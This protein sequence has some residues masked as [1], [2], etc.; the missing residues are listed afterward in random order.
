[1]NEEYCKSSKFRNRF[2]CMVT[3]AMNRIIGK[4]AIKRTKPLKF[5]FHK[6][7]AT[8]GGSIRHISYLLNKA[9]SLLKAFSVNHHK[10]MVLFRGGPLC[11]STWE[12]QSSPVYFEQS[13]TTS[14]QVSDSNLFYGAQG[15]WY[16]ISTV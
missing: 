13:A 16:Q 4:S 1:M 8:R 14:V 2:N 9:V 6:N 12:I 7:K 3:Y 5:Y 15:F 11:Q 10:P